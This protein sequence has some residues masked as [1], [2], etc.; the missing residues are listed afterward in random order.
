MYRYAKRNKI[1]F[2]DE[3]S[4]KLDINIESSFEFLIN[5][6]HK[7]QMELVRQEKKPLRTLKLSLEKELEIERKQ[8]QEK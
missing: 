3:V 5:N 1:N 6:V 7:L 2:I 8:E 4:A